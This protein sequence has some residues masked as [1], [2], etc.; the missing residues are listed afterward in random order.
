MYGDVFKF[1]D[2]LEEYAHTP[3]LWIIVNLSYSNFSLGNSQSIYIHI[4]MEA[5][6]KLIIT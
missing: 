6:G 2:T 1:G 4:L 3:G 5:C